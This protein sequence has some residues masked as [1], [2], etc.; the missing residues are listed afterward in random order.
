MSSFPSNTDSKTDPTATC[1]C[2][3]W[4]CSPCKC[5]NAPHSDPK[6]QV[7]HEALHDEALHDK[8]AGDQIMD[9]LKKV[10]DTLNPFNWGK[11]K[12]KVSWWRGNSI[13]I[14]MSEWRRLVR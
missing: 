3:Q 10:G 13:E 12:D 1:N 7:H 11:D 5:E 6:N 8:N 4:D 2:D 14:I 9:G